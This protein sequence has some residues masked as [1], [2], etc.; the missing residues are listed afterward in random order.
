[1]EIRRGPKEVV[2]FW[3]GFPAHHRMLWAYCLD[4]ALRP[5]SNLGH[6]TPTHGPVQ[7]CVGMGASQHRGRGPASTSPTRPQGSGLGLKLVWRKGAA[8]SEKG[9][10][11][12]CPGPCTVPQSSVWVQAPPM[13]HGCVLVPAH[14]RCPHG[15]H[16]CPFKCLPAKP[17]PPP[18]RCHTDR[19]PPGPSRA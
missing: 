19:C 13:P 5:V 17:P 8:P 7:L 3:G 2:F 12:S 1:M 14:H 16:S 9:I 15:L 4:S 18:N 10:N 6:T 11:H